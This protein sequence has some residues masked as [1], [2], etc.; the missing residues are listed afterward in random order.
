MSEI[1]IVLTWVDQ[2]DPKWQEE[3]RVYDPDGDNPE[4]GDVRYRD[5]NNLQYIFRGI[6][7]FM[8]WVHRVYFV[9]WG[10]I[11]KWLNTDHNKLCVV[12]HRDFIPEKYLPTFNSNVIDLNIF[13]INGLREQFL[14]FN[15]D[16]F[17]IRP[18]KKSDFFVNGKPRDV[19]CIS[20]QP[21]AR[22]CIRNTVINNLEIINDHFSIN[23]VRKNKWK[24]IDFH[25]Y[26]MLAL[27]SLLFM[28]F[29]SII[30]IF[31]P[32]IPISFLKS[33]FEK[34]WDIENKAFEET[35]INKFRTKLD[36]SAWL[37]RYWQLVSGQFEPRSRYF[38]KLVSA[39]DI[40]GVKDILRKP[41]YKM[42]CIN[43]DDSVSNEAFQE[44]KQSINKE[45][46][47]I[48]PDP[49]GFENV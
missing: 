31:E 35:C 14:L 19:A 26:G 11:P 13:R 30:G 8:P 1:D 5:W 15:D 36:I 38:G 29:N 42:I 9:T 28:R 46:E 24:W 25:N 32:H 6:E 21:I 17:V 45:L 7:K 20:P 43:D 41:R 49:C 16:T 18:V 39:S 44:L 47:M 27:R 2:N 40:Q 12:N 22:D 4:G 23:D 10:H 37:V 48:L 33:N 34:L 3:K